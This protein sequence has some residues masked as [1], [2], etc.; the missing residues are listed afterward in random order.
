MLTSRT[1]VKWPRREHCFLDNP[2]AALA[3]FAIAM[4]N[5]KAE[6]RAMMFI[7]IHRTAGAIRQAWNIQQRIGQGVELLIIER[8]C[9]MPP[10]QPD[11]PEN[12]H[13]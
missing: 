2:A 1:P 12:L 3:D 7:L 4:E 5:F 9:V 8:R 6:Q 11:L 10:A 13:A